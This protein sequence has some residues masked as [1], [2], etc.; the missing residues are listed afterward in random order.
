MSA[1]GRQGV[2]YEKELLDRFTI[3]E[4]EAINN[5][6]DYDFYWKTDEIP[7]L[8]GLWLEERRAIINSVLCAKGVCL[9]LP[10][11]G[12]IVL[13]DVTDEK[14]EELKIEV[15]VTQDDLYKG[16]LLVGAPGSG[17]SSELVNIICQQAKLGDSIIVFDPHGDLVDDVVKRIHSSRVKDIFVLD[18][19]NREYPFSANIFAGAVGGDK[20][21][22]EE[23]KNLVLEIFSDIW[24]SVEGGMWFHKFLR[25][26]VGVMIERGDLVVKHIPQF[27]EDDDFREA[28]LQGV[29]DREVLAFWAKFRNWTQNRQEEE[30]APFLERVENLLDD[31]FTSGVLNQPSRCINFREAIEKRRIILVKLPINELATKK[32]AKVV[33]TFLMALVYFAIFSFGDLEKDK[34][35]GVT[36]VVDEWYNFVLSGE[37]F[38]RLL[39]QARKY[40]MKLLLA[41]QGLD[42]MD[43]EELKEVKAAALDANVLMAFKVGKD[44]SKMLESTF[45]GLRVR[46]TNFYTDPINSRKFREHRKDVVREF[47]RDYVVRLKKA[48]RVLTIGKEVCLFDFGFGE[49]EYSP[50]EAENVEQL[51]NNLFYNSQK[52]GSV[53]NWEK[54]RFIEAFGN[55]AHILKEEVEE[56]PQIKKKFEAAKAVYDGVCDKY[57]EIRRRQNNNSLCFNSSIIRNPESDAAKEYERKKKELNFLSIEAVK[58]K[59]EA[60]VEKEKWEKLLTRKVIRGKEELRD[61]EYILDKVLVALIADPIAFSGGNLIGINWEKL[62]PWHAVV[63][64]GGVSWFMKTQNMDEINDLVPSAEYERRVSKIEERTKQEYCMSRL[65]IEREIETVFALQAAP[66]RS[67]SNVEGSGDDSERS[68]SRGGRAAAGRSDKFSELDDN[69]E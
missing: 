36:F 46:P 34:R 30:S 7:L 10:V 62:K 17:K 63:N 54:E 43:K 23:I 45:S 41:C 2:D 39:R 53:N 18:L 57:D 56:D 37:K 38:E 60:E 64:V 26:V 50:L 6:S 5:L 44:S 51:L 55:M 40:G 11:T 32:A 47:Y 8:D 65:D 9:P 52:N 69:E 27:L 21:A 15:K 42:Q 28:C 1:L 22:R 49:T 66:G 29:K 14:G 61:F 13:G 58:R 19:A 12:S 4:L 68:R 35:P 3:E 24:S 67:G 59:N 48:A 33:G 16:S 25:N 31:K 20:D